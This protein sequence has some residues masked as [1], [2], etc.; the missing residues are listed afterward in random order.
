MSKHE[1]DQDMLC[2]FC[3]DRDDNINRNTCDGGN[4]DSAAE[5]YLEDR[6]IFDDGRKVLGQLSVGDLTYRILEVGGVPHL[7]EFEVRALS[8]DEKGAL[9]VNNSYDATI[10]PEE[11]KA[12]S[13]SI[14]FIYKKDAEKKLEEICVERIIKL[15]KMI[16]SVN[17]D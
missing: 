10:T 2:E 16:G 5:G 15:S 6:G 1:I 13:G 17:K 3:Q 7:E 11:L 9:A 14:Y 12:N 4:C 8:K